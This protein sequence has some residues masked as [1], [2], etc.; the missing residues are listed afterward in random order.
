V[1]NVRSERRANTRRSAYSGI[2]TIRR[3]G[4][5]PGHP[6]LILGIP[7]HIAD[8][9]GMESVGA[10]FEAEFTEDG[11]LFKHLDSLPEPPAIDAPSWVNKAKAISNGA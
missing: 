6:N 10:R 2:S 9:L 7:R 1:S 5:T 4:G 11:I 3:T 8:V